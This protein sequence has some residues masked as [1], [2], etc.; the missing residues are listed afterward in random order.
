MKQKP[1]DTNIHE[2]VFIYAKPEIEYLEL[3]H[4]VDGGG[5][6]QSPPEAVPETGERGD[7]SGVTGQLGVRIASDGWCTFAQKTLPEDNS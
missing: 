3:K 5:K 4:A 7:S 6:A 2:T 1:Y